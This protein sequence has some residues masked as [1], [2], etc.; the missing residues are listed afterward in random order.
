MII[1]AG[2][3]RVPD[4]KIEA[5]MP[6]ARATLAASRQEAGCIVYSYAFDLEDRG[7][8][9]VFETWESRAHLEAHV[10]QPHMGPWRDKATEVGAYDRDLKIYEADDGTPM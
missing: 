9:R 1:V 10:K 3:F 5:L 2:T 8:I 4:D 6:T 7:L